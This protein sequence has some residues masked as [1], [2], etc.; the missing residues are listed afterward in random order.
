MTSRTATSCGREPPRA[1]L[2]DDAQVDALVD[3]CKNEETIVFH[4]MLS[5]VRGP[6][7][8]KR[9]ATHPEVLLTS[10]EKK[11]DVQVLTERACC[12]GWSSM[13]VT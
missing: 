10:V 8:A 9:F 6:L 11:L 5:Q 7:C 3:K 13:P 2:H 1:Q 12:S 4:C